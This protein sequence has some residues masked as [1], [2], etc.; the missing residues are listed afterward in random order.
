MTPALIGKANILGG[1]WFKLQVTQVLC[2]EGSRQSKVVLPVL[3]VEG[4]NHFMCGVRTFAQ[5]MTTYAKHIQ[6]S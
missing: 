5:L 3:I 2:I 6:N 4:D 1:W